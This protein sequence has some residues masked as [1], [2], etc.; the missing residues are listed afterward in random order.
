MGHVEGSALC[1]AQSECQELLSPQQAVAWVVW[2][3]GW[4]AC[5]A[6]CG[7]RSLAGRQVGLWQ[8]L[9]VS[10]VEGSGGSSGQC[11]VE[12]RVRR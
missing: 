8:G 4:E 3:L 6:E 9:F 12:L 1:L 10:Q 11:C 2:S 5:S 7:G